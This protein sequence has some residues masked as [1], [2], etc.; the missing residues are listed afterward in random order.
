MITKKGRYKK[1]QMYSEIGNKIAKNL[2]MH[3]G[4]RL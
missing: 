2:F 4:T 3:V 1:G